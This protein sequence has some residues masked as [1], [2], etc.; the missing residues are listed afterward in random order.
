MTTGLTRWTPA[1]DLFRSRFH[2][3]FD[4]AFSDFRTNFDSGEDVAS[5]AWLPAVDISETD[6]ALLV[7]A[8][9]PGM[10]KEDV[11][12]TLENHLLTLRGE[13]QFDR[14][15][16]KENFHRIERSY[17]AFSRSFTLPSNVQ[18]EEVKASFQ[19]GLLT[20]EIPKVEAAKPRKIAIQ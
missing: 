8:E 13:R 20:V 1:T 12:I 11:D 15:E 6:D 5:R 4:E 10:T 17:G 19:D 7:Y 16:K 3:L 2:R 18:A 14:D 9:L